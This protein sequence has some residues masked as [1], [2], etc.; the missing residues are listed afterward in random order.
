[1][2]VLGQVADNITAFFEVRRHHQV[3]RYAAGRLPGSGVLF[4]LYFIDQAL[5]TLLLGDDVAVF[6]TYRGLRE[7]VHWM[8]RDFEIYAAWLARLKKNWGIQS[9]RCWQNLVLMT[10][11]SMWEHLPR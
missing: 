9:T 1:M 4:G 5:V 3:Y 8:A 11:N 2:D 10:L 6:H 7:N